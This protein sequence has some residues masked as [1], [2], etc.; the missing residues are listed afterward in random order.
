MFVCLITLLSGFHKSLWGGW[1]FEP[2]GVFLDQNVIVPPLWENVA[3]WGPEFPLL[4]P[5]ICSYNNNTVL[6]LL[7]V[8]SAKPLYL[9]L[10]PLFSK[11]SC[12]LWTL[13]MQ[14]LHEGPPIGWLKWGSSL[15]LMGYNGLPISCP[16][17]LKALPSAW[18]VYHGSMQNT[19]DPS[20]L[21]PCRSG[22]T[23]TAV[24]VLFMQVN[25]L[26]GINSTIGCKNMTV[27]H[28]MEIAETLKTPVLFTLNFI[29]TYSLSFYSFLQ[30]NIQKVI[31][32]VPAWHSIITGAAEN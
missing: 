13:W 2:S 12:F 20:I 18:A 15:I 22:V 9:G 17:C 29:R 3:Q 27:I 23:L 24:A 8:Y 1:A 19:L 4:G 26:K 21:F 6:S 5:V 11:W 10:P 25:G 28:L 32:I 14:F 31:W 16:L 30:L 7:L